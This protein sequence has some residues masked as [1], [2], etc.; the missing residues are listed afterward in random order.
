MVAANSSLS[1]YSDKLTGAYVWIL[2]DDDLLIYPE[3]VDDL[4]RIVEEHN[5][6]VIFV[7]MNHGPLGILPDDN[8]WQT[9]P[10]EG[11]IG[12]SAYVVE[13]Q[14]WQAHASA[15]ASGR[16][17]SDFDFINSVWRAGPKVYWHDVVASRVQR[18]SNGA[19]E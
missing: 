11:Y 10:Q 15:F 18:I 8:H 6:Q 1:D 12:V 16:Y 17:Q 13:R 3:L 9:P 7:K 4:K 5:P 14:L 2:D 19:P